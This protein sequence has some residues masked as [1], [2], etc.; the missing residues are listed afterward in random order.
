M[1]SRIIHLVA[2]AQ[3][4]RAPIQNVADRIAGVF[5]PAV[6][7][8][9][10][11]AFVLWM[12]FGPEP[13]VAHAV[14]HAVAVLIIACPCALGLATPISIMVAVGRG[15][16]LG[17][18]IKQAE[19]IERLEH[20]D[21]LMIDKTGTLTEGKPRVSEIA[22]ADD[23]EMSENEFLA[24][25]AA[26]E[27]RSEHPLAG[28]LVHEARQEREL[29]LPEVEE[30]ESVTG[31]GVKGS[32]S[33]RDLTVGKRSFIEERCQFDEDEPAGEH[34]LMKRA[35]NWFGEGEAKTVIYVA[36]DQEL[37]GVISLAD[38]IKPTTPDALRGIREM[39]VEVRMLTGDNEKTA[40]AVAK[41]LGLEH[42]DSGVSPERKHELV[43]QA[44]DSGK[45]VAMAGDG[46]NDAPALAA[47]TVGIAMGTGTDVAIESADISLPQGDL[48]AV[49]RALR[50]SQATMR[51]IRQNLFFAY[52]YNGLGVPIAAGILYPVVG[53]SLSPMLAAAAM[54][55]SSVSVITNAL[56][57][58]K[59]KL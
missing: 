53:L 45:Q 42:Y 16:S 28:A 7:A 58:R 50:L 32:V 9:A 41:E 44:L 21:L 36:L 38:P 56:R 59:V 10:V 40:A 39:G 25:V 6:V 3:R 43:K 35:D 49:E 2:E 22:V 30:F 11:L 13:R 26:L 23:A 4:S 37:V 46:I 48:R 14:V 57:L 18:L 12:I 8:V 34:P 5:V 51:N 20:V 15:A 54:S 47:A 17:L 1:L 55:L 31:Q 33:G 24:M 29:E 19:A 52:I 27:N